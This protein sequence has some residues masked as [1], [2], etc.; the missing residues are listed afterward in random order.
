M[1]RV[2]RSIGNISAMYMCGMLSKFAKTYPK[3][4]KTNHIPNKTK[5]KQ[6]QKNQTNERGD[7]PALDPPMSTTYFRQPEKTLS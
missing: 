5:T 3:Q 7:A 1:D 2:L 4:N 6:K